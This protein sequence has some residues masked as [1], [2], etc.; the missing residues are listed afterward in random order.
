MRVGSSNRQG[1]TLIEMLIV[2]ALIALF[3]GL[4]M[5]G[6][7]QLYDDGR[8]KAMFDETK[9]IGSNLSFAY[10]DV[11]FYPRIGLL[12]LSMDYI[13]FSN[14][15]A[16]ALTYYCR[17]GMDT[18]GFY[19]SGRFTTTINPLFAIKNWRA[20]YMSISELRA[21]HSGGGKSGV[22]K[23]R[24][25]DRE[26]SSFSPG[27]ST[28][29]ANDD[30]SLVDW[31]TDTWGNPY[32]FYQVVSDPAYV[33]GRN[34]HG[35][36]LVKSPTE[37]GSY[38]TAV[39]SYG[40]NKVPGGG[41]DIYRHPGFPLQQLYVKGDLVQTN[42]PADYT[43]KSYTASDARLKLDLTTGAMDTFAESVQGAQAPNIGIM[44]TGSDDIY[45]KFN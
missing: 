6:A 41:E 27:N 33:S 45:F 42:G 21:M 15:T 30:L 2:A 36:R 12:G 39:V 14:G 44:D 13:R 26:Y 11:G 43:L 35:L 10:Q 7:Q 32:M 17:P 34:T 19:G 29:T 5:I 23:M 16:P 8:R 31:P 20:P 38:F 3:A 18:Y 28:Q 40:R 1:F 22:V 37:E 24:L 4:A 25:S 9:S